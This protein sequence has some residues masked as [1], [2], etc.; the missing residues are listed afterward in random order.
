MRDVWDG[1]IEGASKELSVG[2]LRIGDIE[3]SRPDPSLYW[4]NYKS[5]D[6][7]YDF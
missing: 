3:F 5:V 1:S 4:S 6:N 7:E 2:C